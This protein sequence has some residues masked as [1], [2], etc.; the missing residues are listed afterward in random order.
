MAYIGKWIYNLYD[1]EDRFEYLKL[2]LILSE[3]VLSFDYS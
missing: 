1:I 2:I 3:I